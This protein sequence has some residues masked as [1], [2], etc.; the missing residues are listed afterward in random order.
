MT[1]RYTHEHGHD[2]PGHHDCDQRRGHHH[3][4]SHHGFG[5][6]HH[7]AG[8]NKRS[9]TIALL[10][11]GGILIAELVG[12]LVTNS[13]ALLSDAAHMFSDVAALGLSLLAIWFASKPATLQRTYGFY[14]AEVLA[15][16]GN[17]V[18]L[19]VVSLYIF[20][21]AYQRFQ[22]PPEVKSGLM[23]AVAG[24]GLAANL[25]SAWVLSRGGGHHHNLNVRGAFLHV[26]GDALGSAGAI[27][28]ALIMMYTDWYYADPVISVVIGVLVLLSS[29]RLLR[30]TV[31]VL[32]EGTPA[33]I[34]L[35]KLRKAMHAVG[36]VQQV[37]DLH[38]WSVS[39]GFVCMSGHVVI[40]NEQD[41]QRILRQL[42]IVL[43][44]KFGLSH[45][46]IQIETEN[47]HP[48]TEDC[49]HC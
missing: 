15:A 43:R 31:H 1:D 37:H 28:A 3:G 10:M 29:Y 36:G 42:E 7:H 33:H 34:D 2:H 24:I 26:L 17:A 18:T 32:L 25:A 20:W 44:E 23:L 47:L 8:G 49:T 27:A 13:L 9:L 39:S 11:T 21:E 4:H 40:E 6:H 41:G 30:D 22:N 12:G 48:D 19:V 38:V 16:L 45:T 5:R 35:G 46:T 14:R